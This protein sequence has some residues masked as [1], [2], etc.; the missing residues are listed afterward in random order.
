MG[1]VL[2]VEGVIRL[3]TVDNNFFRKLNCK[4]IL[5]Y[6][7]LLDVVAAADLDSSLG[8]EVLDDNVSH[9]LS[10]CVSFLVEAVHSVEVG[11]ERYELAV[12]GSAKNGIGC[13]VN[14]DTPDPVLHFTDFAEFNTLLVPESD[15]LVTAGHDEV[16]SSWVERDATGI[17][18]K[19]FVGTDR[20][21]GFTA[22]N[23]EDR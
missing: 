5:V 7:D 22:L 3:H 8:H 16:L 11:A 14:G 6:G 15:G 20:L 12:V 19:V 18:T 4:T 9:Q 13:L 17:E 2:H 21:D 10:I 23:C 1:L